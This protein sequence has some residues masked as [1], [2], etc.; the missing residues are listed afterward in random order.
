VLLDLLGAPAPRV[1][2][3]F[4]DTHWAY[5]AM[6]RIEAR[7]RALGQLRTAG[8][9][10]APFLP[11]TGDN[12][13]P[14]QFRRGYIEDDHIPFMERGVPI[15]HVIPS[16]FPA[17]WHTMD[18]DGEHLDP[19]AVEDWAK[20]VTGFAAEWL[21]LDGFMTSPKQALT[22]QKKAQKHDEGEKGDESIRD[23]SEL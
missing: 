16:P 22:P 3:Y 12:L 13:A 21:E 2:S 7:L 17:T 1:P 23:R 10:G 14:N 20:I 5:E 9:G 19:S 4:R 15:L 8:G 18:D 11:E 6:A